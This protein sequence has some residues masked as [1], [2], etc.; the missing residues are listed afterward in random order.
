MKTA[1]VGVGNLLMADEG[2]GVRVVEALE[3]RGGT[4]GAD[5]YDAGTGFFSVVSQLVSYERLFIIDAIRGGGPPGTIY[6]FELD[7]DTLEDESSKGGGS[8]GAISVH[9]IGV[10]RALKF[11]AITGKLPGRIVL[12]GAEPSRV[13][14]S[15]EISQ[16]LEPV[17]ERLADLVLSEIRQDNKT[18]RK[19]NGSEYPKAG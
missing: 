11:Q 2:L 17:I 19:G 14:L 12:F 10:I 7:D 16:Q 15:L 5:L 6:R 9:D 1:I 4:D 18:R 13:E 8:F 3:R